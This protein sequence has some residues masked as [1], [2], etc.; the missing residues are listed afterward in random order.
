MID[1]GRLVDR[2]EAILTTNPPAGVDAAYAAGFFAR[3]RAALV[4][5]VGAMLS[6]RAEKTRPPEPSGTATWSAEERQALPRYVSASV[7]HGLLAPLV[8]TLHGAMNSESAYDI[9]LISSPTYGDLV[10]EEVPLEF[11]PFG[12]KLHVEADPRDMHPAFWTD[13]LHHLQRELPSTWVVSIQPPG[14]ENMLEAYSSVDPPDGFLIQI[15]EAAANALRED[16][17]PAPAPA[18]KDAPA[19]VGVETQEGGRA[20]AEL[21]YEALSEKQR[22]VVDMSAMREDTTP[23]LRH[24]F[25]S[26]LRRV[27]MNVT[28]FGFDGSRLSPVERSVDRYI[29]WDV[30]LDSGRTQAMYAPRKVFEEVAPPDPALIVPDIFVRDGGLGGSW[31]SPA[32]MYEYIDSAWRHI[33]DDLI[34]AER[35][36]L[37]TKR[38]EWLNAATAHRRQAQTYLTAYEAWVAALRPGMTV[39]RPD[40]AH[41][42]RWRRMVLDLSN[43]RSQAEEWELRRITQTEQ[44]RADKA[45]RVG[46]QV[47]RREFQREPERGWWIAAIAD[48]LVTLSRSPDELAQPITIPVWLIDLDTTHFRTPAAPALS[49]AVVDGCQEVIF[50]FERFGRI[51]VVCG[52]RGR[53]DV[54]HNIYVGSVRYGFNGG[55]WAKGMRPPD[56]VL[57]AVRQRGITVFGA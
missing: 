45:F 4:E 11:F 34:K 50:N 22:I 37:P 47:A 24:G 14:W 41:P 57:T 20:G 30:T 29:S 40:E 23:D 6:Q 5:M 18:A 13:L 39:A 48:G 54:W 12:Y 35:A 25:V 16:L 10:A 49:S 33:A 31:Y 53:R 21:P 2:M 32:T 19:V 42:V 17:A 26:T 52:A 8:R 7:A 43:H 1:A 9:V 27:S 56:E 38:Q 55:R 15:P 36:K 46:E 28:S 51:H 3:N 44:T